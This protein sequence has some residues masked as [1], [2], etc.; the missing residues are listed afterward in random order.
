MEYQ[1]IVTAYKNKDLDTSDLIKKLEIAKPLKSRSKYRAVDI[2][3]NSLTLNNE[4]TYLL[5]MSEN[6]EK[7]VKFL[8]NLDILLNEYFSELI[9]SVKNCK[10]WEIIGMI[11]KGWSQREFETLG[12]SNKFK[13]LYDFNKKYY[14]FLDYQRVADIRTF[15]ICDTNLSDEKVRKLDFLIKM[16]DLFKNQRI[17]D[18]FFCF[19]KEF[20]MTLINFKRS[21]QLRIEEFIATKKKP[22]QDDYEKYSRYFSN[23]DYRDII[24]NIT[25]TSKTLKISLSKTI[26]AF[27]QLSET[28]T[29]KSHLADDFKDLKKLEKKYLIMNKLKTKFDESQKQIECNKL[30]EKKKEEL[31]K[32]L[33]KQVKEKS[34]QENK[35]IELKKQEVKKLPNKEQVVP[36]ILTWFEQEDVTLTRRISIKKMNAFFEKIKQI[37]LETGKKANLFFVTN[38]NKESTAKRA[39]ELQK[40]STVQGLPNLIEA[41]FGGYSTF[42]IDK[43][44]DI[45]DIAQM[46]ELNRTKIINLLEKPV[47]HYLSSELIIKE[48]KNYLR[49][50]FSDR[51][52]RNVTVQYLR[53]VINQLLEDEKIK[54]QPL[55]F[56]PYVERSCSGIDVVLESQLKGIEQIPE[57]YKIKYGVSSKDIIQVNVANIDEFIEDVKPV[58]ENVSI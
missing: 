40:K 21:K 27:C 30:K 5:T 26:D 52:N 53:N 43:N 34:L 24:E 50:Q 25:L 16:F 29:E 54:K 28:E 49:Y 8:D 41:T 38:S 31:K 48:E 7:S 58:I 10:A 15:I 32:V 2:V 47:R 42:K 57:Y 6:M 9:S 22:I 14:K 37:E 13:V 11:P 19:D 46:S 56:L 17:K 18:E 39:I 44:G 45:T 20:L 55:K 33:E 23:K 4:I 1:E 35:V 36:I 12:K 51:K 3:D